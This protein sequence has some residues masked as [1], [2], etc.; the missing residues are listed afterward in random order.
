MFVFMAR[1]CSAAVRFGKNVAQDRH[2]RWARTWS[3]ERPVAVEGL[4]VDLVG[5]RVQLCA[6]SHITSSD[7][8]H[9]GIDTLLI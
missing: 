9:G 1:S 4:G 2:P 3:Q 7:P 5:G 8:I 6:V